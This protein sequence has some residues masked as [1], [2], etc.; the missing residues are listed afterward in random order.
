MSEQNQNK[1]NSAHKSHPR[2][3][4]GSKYVY[5]VLSRRSGGISIGI[6]LSPDKICNFNCI[7]C[8]VKRD[9]EEVK[10]DRASDQEIIDQIEIE[11]IELT[12]MVY[13]GELFNYEPFNKIP[14][15]FRKLCDI[16]FSGDGE[17]TSFPSFDLVCSKIADIRLQYARDIVK[18]VLITNSS[19]LHKPKVQEGLAVLDMN[20]GE[21]WAK[22]DAGTEKYYQMVNRS[23]VSFQKIIDN[24]LRT[25]QKRPLKIQSLFMNI[26][27]QIPDIEEINA[28]ADKL[29]YLVN[30]GANIISVQIHTIARQPAEAYAKS[31]SDTEIDAISDLVHKK[32]SLTVEKFYGNKR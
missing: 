19:L 17:P 13:S 5:P 27:G 15:E 32:T 3:F 10:V 25:A 31:L 2:T 20:N 7:Y 14:P 6:N 29:I 21:I 12:Q 4:H 1:I 8:Q 30:N 23:E 26:L 22:L 11:L 9:N 18:I 16:S 28:Y 24:I